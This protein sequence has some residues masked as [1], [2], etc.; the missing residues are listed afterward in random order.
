MTSRLIPL[1]VLAL[2]TSSG[3]TFEAGDWFA[4]VTASFEGSYVT[5]ADRDVGGGWQKL[6]TLY[7]A[8]VTRALVTVE[9]IALQDLGGDGGGVSFDPAHPPPGYS[10]C[11]NGHC[12]ANDG[13]LVPY[14]EIEAELAGGGMA[15]ARTVV[16][17]PVG[18][19]DL[20]AAG[21]RGLEC[22]PQ[23]GL[24]EANVRRARATVTR[25]V[26]EGLVREGRSPARLEGE[27][28]WRW[29]AALATGTG[30]TTGTLDVE[31]D[32]PADNAHPPDVGL[33]LTLA[34][35]ARLLD[36][37]DW[38][39]LARD[40]AGVID[41]GTAANAPAGEQL[42]QNLAESELTANIERND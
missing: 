34:V 25:V 12:H 21:R 9:S 33:Q 35:G 15:A 24:G 41:A 30:P 37:V 17:F 31:I 18:E 3:C 7:Q 2:G 20:L 16:S 23:C 42:G 6:N 13:R 1:L 11:H 4:N 36:D 5:R 39:S 8:R 32:L 27:V 29:E 14:A 28:P 10:L 22:E 19:T 38:A 40:G 26:F